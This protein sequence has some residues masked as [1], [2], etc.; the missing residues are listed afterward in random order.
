M[1]IRAKLFVCSEERDLLH[2]NVDYHRF[3]RFN[4]KPS[5]WVMGGYLTVTFRSQMYDDSF[6]EW[7]LADRSDNKHIE[8]PYNLYEL[9]DGK[10]VFYKDDSDD[11]VLFEYNFKDA[12][13]IEY[14]EVFDNQNDMT[15]TLTISPAIQDYRFFGNM[16][17]DEKSP[18]RFIKTWEENYIPPTKENSYNPQEDT[19]PRYKSYYTDLQGNKK[20]EVTTG[21]EVYLVIE[22]T[23]AIGETINIDLSDH[24]K[25]F[26]YNDKVIENDIIK[27]FNI[28]SNEHKLKL[29]VIVQQEGEREKTQ[30]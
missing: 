10:I 29:L 30:N 12:T 22:S 5:S 3:T 23:N 15:V 17:W 19:T 26:I 11:L 28:T 27:D 8:Y 1:S 20:A 21:E 13:L 14:Y 2:T 18:T 4:G 25:D 16:K 6:I 9:R 7:M 24:T